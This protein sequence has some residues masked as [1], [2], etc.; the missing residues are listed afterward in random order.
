MPMSDD[1][2]K[3]GRD[4][5][6]LCHLNPKMISVLLKKENEGEFW[7]QQKERPA[8]FKF[9]IPYLYAPTADLR[10]DFRRFVF[11]Q[12][13]ARR[14]DELLHAEWNTRSRLRLFPYRKHDG[15]EIVARDAEVQKL[16]RTFQDENLNFYIDKPIEDFEPDDRIIINTGPWAGYE[17][18]VI[19]TKVSDGRAKMKVGLN[20]F[21]LVESVVFTNLMTGDVIFKDSDKAQLMSNEPI[22][23]FE[24]EVI[25]ILSHRYDKGKSE[26][27]QEA[28]ARKLRQLSAFD[29]VLVDEEDKDYYR[30]LSLRLICAALRGS[31]KK[32]SLL[33]EVNRC[34]GGRTNP[35]TDDEAYMMVALFVATKDADYRTALKDYRSSH[36]EAHDIL[37]RY[38]S[39]IKKMRAKP[40]SNIQ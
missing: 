31:V 2:N 13:S 5:Y 10:G 19:E 28:D 24:E 33:K 6:I 3:N 37:R 32:E 39:I 11:V 17:G 1:S 16:I 36:P 29:R 21:N 8:P 4:W 22:V 14:I 23:H 15:T 9:F 26:D 18:V 38:L 40:H 30:F 7:N 12:A 35:E 27:V 20:L 25:D 34:V